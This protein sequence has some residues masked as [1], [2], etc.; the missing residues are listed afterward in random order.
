MRF[1]AILLAPLIEI[2]PG[3]FNPDIDLPFVLPIHVGQEWGRWKPLPN[4]ACA[5]SFGKSVP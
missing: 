2:F 3:K 4:A 5:V 1:N